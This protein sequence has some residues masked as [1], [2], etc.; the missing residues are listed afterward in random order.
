MTSFG[1]YRDGSASPDRSLTTWIV[2]LA[3]P[4]AHGIPCTSKGEVMKLSLTRGSL[5]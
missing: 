1:I 4:R 3:D 2:R 5:R